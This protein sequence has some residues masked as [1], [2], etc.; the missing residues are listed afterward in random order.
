MKFLIVVSEY[1]GKLQITGGFQISSV[2]TVA[3]MLELLE[4]T[5]AIRCF[6]SILLMCNGKI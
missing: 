5:K 1:E 3:L 4:N 2:S 6:I